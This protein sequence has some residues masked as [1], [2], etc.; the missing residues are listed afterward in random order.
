MPRR[1]NLT[2]LSAGEMDLL[3][4]LWER[5]P[6]TLAQ[7]HQVFDGYGL[8]I[9]YPTMQTRLNRL[10]VKGFVAR[11]EARPAAY[12]AVLSPEQSAA[13]VLGQILDK[14]VSGSVAPLMSSLISERP[15]TAEEIGDIRELLNEAERNNRKQP[16][17]KG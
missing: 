4:M 8:A 13:G 15:L 12:R 10:V 3:R 6:L 9:A 11:N 17:R 5:G 1:R 7:A 14:L 2:R 16:K